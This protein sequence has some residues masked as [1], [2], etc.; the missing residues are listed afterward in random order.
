MGLFIKILIALHV[1][2]GCSALISGAIAMIFKSTTA[3]HRIAGKIYFWN[4]TFIFVSGMYLAVYRNSLFFIFISFF[5]YHQLIAAYRSLKLKQLHN[6]QAVERIDW[7]IEIVA[8]TANLCFM[9]FAGYWYMK[10]KGEI[11]LIPLVFGTIGLRNVYKNVRL[12]IKKTNDPTY[13]LQRHIAGMVGSYIGAITAFLVNQGHNIK[14]IPEIVLWLAPTA[15]LTPL[16]IFETRK[17]K[18]AFRKSQI[19]KV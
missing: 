6:G 8:G 9:L 1:T 16:I 7:I 4:M 17:L 18:I 12:F 19:A 14:F 5:V 3:K 10:G 15:I 11:A 13:W 2:A